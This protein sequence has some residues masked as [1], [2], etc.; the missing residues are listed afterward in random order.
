MAEGPIEGSAPLTAASS[1]PTSQQRKKLEIRLCEREGCR[2]R[3]RRNTTHPELSCRCC[4]C[5]STECEHEHLIGL[6]QEKLTDQQVKR[7]DRLCTQ[8]A[9]QARHGRKKRR[10]L[11][12]QAEVDALQQQAVSAVQRAREAT[13]HLAQAASDAALLQAKEQELEAM[14]EAKKREEE[15][16]AAEQARVAAVQAEADRLQDENEQLQNDLAA[17]GKEAAAMK[18]ELDQLPGPTV[19]DS[20]L[21]NRGK[22][23][24][25]HL[26]RGGF[27]RVDYML[28]IGSG[29]VAVKA[30]ECDRF[31]RSPDHRAC[32]KMLVN[33]LK[34]MHSCAACPNVLRVY[35]L[36]GDAPHNAFVMEAADCDL[37]HRI[38]RAAA[39][40]SSQSSRGFRAKSVPSQAWK[41]G[42]RLIIATGV[43]N[44]LAFL[45]R[46]VIVHCD[47]NTRNILLIGGVAKIADFG[48]AVYRPNI[49]V[50][51]A[52]FPLLDQV[53]GT[54]NFY[55]PEKF[56]AMCE[57]TDVRASPAVDVWAFGCVLECLGTNSYNPSHLGQW[58][59]PRLTF[60]AAHKYFSQ[61]RW[62]PVNAAVGEL[63]VSDVLRVTTLP[64]A[65]QRP[66]MENVYLAM[67]GELE[68]VSRRAA[69]GTDLFQTQYPPLS[70][71]L[72]RQRLWQRQGAAVLVEDLE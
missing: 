54:K 25:A 33:E 59:T 15:K 6:C 24:G 14:R 53:G 67:A 30:I 11:M 68:F 5:D 10:V 26:G 38:I 51:Q 42:E 31:S 35:G 16:V 72:L 52:P 27:G 3:W 19:A 23:Q 61:H 48:L 41:P 7:S 50:D 46:Q 49:R 22:T 4:R 71:G 57:D 58:A 39:R 2:L 8:C 65:T 29:K 56:A 64:K 45:H 21:W 17:R 34:L 36:F 69:S 66:T 47:L 37:Y 40:S 43:A 1:E 32:M 63:P 18:H 55:D 70:Q 60:E 12:Q 20:C 28:M 9:S 44:G 13:S 62:T